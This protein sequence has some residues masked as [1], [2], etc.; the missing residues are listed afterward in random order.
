M[1]VSMGITV[2][3]SSSDAYAGLF[4]Q[5]LGFYEPSC[6]LLP[7]I[8]TGLPLVTRPRHTEVRRHVRCATDR[9]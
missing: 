8:P 5:G 7:R 2:I 1:Y 6:P 4:E 9:A 3:R